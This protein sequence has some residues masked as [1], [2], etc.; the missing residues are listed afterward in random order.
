ERGRL[1]D[2]AELSRQVAR[3]L[4]DPRSERFC[5]SFATQWLR[6]RKVGMFPPDKNL[7][8]NYDKTLEASMIAETKAFFSEVLRRGLTMREF[9]D[10]DW[11]MTNARLAEYY[12]LPSDGLPR[13]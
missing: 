12:G 11:T 6:L 8:S 13:D 4:A 9:L 3:M 5:D 7:Y 2:K 1:H 10:S